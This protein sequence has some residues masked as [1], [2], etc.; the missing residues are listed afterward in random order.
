[1]AEL[2]K[3][4]K[5]AKYS[6]VK[7]FIQSGNV[8]LESDK[9]KSEIEKSIEAIIKKNFGGEIPCV[10]KSVKELETILK[11][12]PFSEKDRAQI[13]FTMLASRPD[14]KIQKEL[15]KTDFSPDKVGIIGEIIYTRYNTKVSDSKFHNNFFERKLGVKATTRNFNTMTKVLGLA[16]EM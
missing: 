15:L 6:N 9:S 10:A 13:Y 5:K 7:T 1:M 12:N 3:A 16:A 11:K 2:R 4:L 14:G 8:I